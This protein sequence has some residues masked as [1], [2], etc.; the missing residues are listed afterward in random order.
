MQWINFL[1]FY[2]PGN[3][4]DTHI[5]E[6][7]EKS[8]LRIVDALEKNPHI[9]FTVNIN[10]CLILRWENL[11]YFGLIGRIK[12]LTDKKQIELVGTASFHPLLPLIPDGEIKNQIKENETILKKFFG[13]SL[14]L[15]GFFMPEMAYGIQAAKIIKSFG[16]EYLILGE[17]ARPGNVS[18]SGINCP[19]I[20]EDIDS[21]LKLVFRNRKLSLGYVPDIIFNILKQGGEPTVVTATDAELYGLR[22]SDPEKIFE[23]LLS[24]DRLKT[25]TLSDF[26]RDKKPEKIKVV[27]STWESSETELKN[28]QPYAIWADNSN[29]LQANLWKMADLAIKT[30]EKFKGDENDYWAR[31]HLVRGLASCTFWWAS[32]RDFKNIFGPIA[33]NPDE[34]EKGA[35]ELA[36]SVRSLENPE[37]KFEKIKME[38]LYLTTIGLIW[39]MHWKKYW[40]NQN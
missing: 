11:G 26:I 23:K 16:Y 7:T 39:K 34:I 27:P 22:H 10:G 31:W 30:T 38:K 9:R 5:K 8:Y 40:K 12:K 17:A 19:E 25:L 4:K 6:A 18:D 24:D 21:G 2:Q 33:W 20:Y 28:N 3:S 1:H 36:R 37:S 35:D 32:G 13:S 29:P 15:H 14:K